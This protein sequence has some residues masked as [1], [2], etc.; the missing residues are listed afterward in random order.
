MAIKILYVSSHRNFSQ[1]FCHPFLV[2]LKGGDN[3]FRK[4][5]SVIIALVL[6]TV[7]AFVAPTQGTARVTMVDA[8]GTVRG[9]VLL[10]IR[11]R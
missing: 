7:S 6:T 10:K 9:R 8:L 2:H 3:I 4:M 5:Q 1:S 11:A